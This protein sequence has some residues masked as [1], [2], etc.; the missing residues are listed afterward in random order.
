MSSSTD[1]S[2]ALKLYKEGTTFNHPFPP[3]VGQFHVSLLHILIFRIGILIFWS[4]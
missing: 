4:G 3:P 1:I 2:S